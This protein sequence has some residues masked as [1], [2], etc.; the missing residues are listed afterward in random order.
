MTLKASDGNANEV[1]MRSWI[2]EDKA[3][4]LLQSCQLDFDQLKTQAL[5]KDFKPVVLSA[6][7]SAQ[8]NNQ[9]RDVNSYNFVARLDGKDKKKQQERIV[10]TAHWDHL[11][12]TEE[13]GKRQIF[14][15]AVDNATGIAVLLEIAR[16]FKRHHASL[17]RSVMFMAVTAEEKGL[18][19]SQYYADNPLYP[20][21]DTLAN[22]NMD[23]L[24]PWGKVRDVQVIGFGQ[25]T[26]DALVSDEA[27]KQGRTVMPDDRPENGYYFRSDHFN[28][29]KKGVPA[30]YL[31][32][33]IDVIGKEPGYG[34]SRGK[35]FTA[36]HYHKDGDE[37]RADWDMDGLVQDGEL[38]FNV[39][40][41]LARDL[42]DVQFVETSEFRAAELARKKA[43]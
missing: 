37:V 43:N 21:K 6:K 42:V 17:K 9:L 13:N 12:V 35:E 31:K 14:N 26:F 22:F 36:E 3:R 41:R 28:F 7:A 32:G 24:Q 18:L 5:R 15:G 39:G 8:I 40:Q 27:K 2:R 38:Y 20:L 25:T 19:G 29:A 11:G 33:G 16:E 4:A 10:Y 34:L 23:A 30:M 1:A